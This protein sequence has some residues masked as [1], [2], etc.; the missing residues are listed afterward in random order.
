MPILSLW[1]NK[2][3]ISST[4]SVVTVN[5]SVI[6]TAYRIFK[7]LSPF[8]RTMSKGAIT[9]KEFTLRRWKPYKY[10][11]VGPY[12]LGALCLIALATTLRI[13]LILNWPV[14]NSD[15]G[16]MGLMALHIVNKGK[17]HVFFYVQGY[18]GVHDALLAAPLFHL[19]GHL[20][21]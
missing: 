19:I 5:C 21:F 4:R 11:H 6:P 15:E 12:G 10:L 18:F 8:D 1:A 3:G 16:T 2:I 14:L 7:I 13:V 9:R 17:I 20:D